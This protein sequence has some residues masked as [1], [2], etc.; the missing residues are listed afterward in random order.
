MVPVLYMQLGDVVWKVFADG[1]W[2][3]V[4]N[5]EVLLK[6]VQ[7]VKQEVQELGEDVQLSETQIA[8]TERVLSQTINNLSN[9][10]TNANGTV[11]ETNSGSS[12][13]AGFVI[14]LKAT[15]D[16]TIAEAGFDTRPGI[17]D[18]Q[19]TRP[20]LLALDILSEQA[21][22]T[23][24]ILDGGDGYENQFEVPNVTIVGTTTDVRD[25]RIV[26]ITISD[27]QGNIVEAQAITQDNAYSATGVVLTELMEG[28]LSVNAAVSD[29][30]GNSISANDETIKDTLA[31]ITVEADGF[32]DDY[33]NA[34]EVS[35]SAYLGSVANVESGQPINWVITDEQGNSITGS[36]TVD[37]VGVW[38]VNTL[39]V[40]TLEDGVLIIEAST[41][42]IA[43]NPANST[44][45]IIKDTQAFITVSIDDMDGV[46]NENEITNSTISGTVTD[47][48]DGQIVEIV[49]TGQNGSPLNL[50]ATVT[51]SAWSVSGVDLSSF[52][53]GPLNVVASTVDVAGN[54]ASAADTSTIDVV[55]PTIDIDTLQ[56]FNILS[57]RAGNLTTLQGTTGL[58]EEGLPVTVIVSDGVTTLEFQGNV[59]N[60]GNWMVNGIDIGLLDKGV[61]WTLDAKVSNAV[62]NTAIDDMPTIILPESLAFSDTVVGIFGSQDKES[63]IRIQNADFKFYEE[64][65]LI[66]QL[67]S[68]GLSITVTVTN[69]VI[70]GVRSDGETVFIATLAGDSVNIAF[71]EVIDQDAP[72][73]SI[74]TALLV[75]GTQTDAD[76]TTE[77]VIGHLPINIV[78]I[79]PVLFND[80]YFVTE[81]EVRSG[82]V[83]NNDIDLDGALTIYKII[84]DNVEYAIS[85]STPTVVTLSEGQLS[86]FA[87]GH[88]NFA[89][90]RNQDASTNPKIQ[91][92][93]FASDQENDFGQA[94]ATI[95]IRDGDA[96]EVLEGS[97]SFIE[98]DADLRPQT[99]NAQFS[100]APGSDNPDPNSLFFEASTINLLDNLALTSGANLLALSYSLNNDSTVITATSGSQT[101]FTITLSG[102]V[103]SGDSTYVTGNVK[104]ILERPLNHP[105]KNDLLKLPL[106]I[107][108]KDTDGTDLESGEFTLLIEDGSDPVLTSISDASVSESDVSTDSASGAGQFDVALGADDLDTN[109]SNNASVY[110]EIGEQPLVYSN[111]EEV[112]Y[113]LSP[114]GSILT[115]YIGDISNVVFIISFT[116]PD[117]S[118]GGLVDYTFEL[119]QQIDNTSDPMQLP[120]IVTA[121]DS[122]KDVTK[123]TLNVTVNDSGEASLGTTALDVTE[124]PKGTAPDEITTS[125]S[126]AIFITASE[127]NIVEVDLGITS[128]NAVVDSLG[129]PITTN[130][131]N[132]VWRDNGDKTFD[133]VD[134]NGV[135]VFRVGLPND[136]EVESG[137]TSSFQLSFRVFKEVDHG[138]DGSLNE[139][140]INL[141]V[142]ARDVD[143]TET[144]AVSTVK[145]YDG[146]DPSLVTHDLAIYE[147]LLAD[148]PEVDIV[149]SNALEFVRGS[150]AIVAIDIDLSTF[151]AAGYSSG[152]DNIMLTASNID[153]WYIASQAI[154]GEEV[155]RIRLNLDGSAEFVLTKP[156]DHPLGN[157]TNTLDIDF[158]VY[159][160]DADGDISVVTNLT[161]VVTDDVPSVTSETLE[162]TEG[163]TFSG[164]LLST[165][166]M[167]V[168]GA[169]ITSFKYE[170]TEYD[171]L[172]NDPEV[173]TLTNQNNANSSYGTLTLHSDGRYTIATDTNVDA[174]P[175]LVDDIEF[176][177]TDF[178]G[179]T[180]TSTASL[181]LDDSTG[182]IRVTN[183]EIREDETATLDIKVYVGDF[184]Q[185]ENVSAITLSDLQGGTLYLDSV[186]LVPDGSGVVTLTDAQISK[187]AGDYFVPDGVLTYVPKQNES[188]TTLTGNVV[189]LVIGA[190]I[191]R[192]G[193]A[194]E[195]VN[196][197]NLDISVLPVADAPDWAS[198]QFE[199]ALTEDIDRTFPLNIDAQLAD[200]D[201]SEK[202]SYQIS[203]IPNGI[204]IKLDGSK[205]VEG[206]SYTQSQLDQMTITVHK[207]L[208]G[209]FSFD[210]KAIATEK[211]NSFSSPDDKTEEIANVVVIKVSPDADQPELTVKDIRGLED[212]TIDLK[213]AIFGNL[214]D[215]DGS[216]TLKYDIVVQDG[217]SFTGSGYQLISA[218]TYRVDSEAI[219]NSQALLVPKQD[220][221]S[222]TESL[223]IQVTAVA[224][225]STIDGLAPVN[226]EAYSD[227]KTINIHLKGVVDPPIA[228]DGGNG[229]WDFDSNTNTIQSIGSFLEDGLVPLD[230]EFITSD[231]DVSETLNILITNIPDDISLVDSAG[232]PVALTIAEIDPITGNIYQ[233]SNSELAALYIKPLED[234]SGRMT[235]DATVVS[236]EQDGDSGSFD[237]TVQIDL[238]PVVDQSDGLSVVTTG[239][240]DAQIS[241][242]L[243]PRISGDNDKS[244]TLTGYIIDSVPSDLTLYFDGTVISVPSSGLDLETLLD[245]TT[246]TLDSLLNS[247]RLSVVPK[248][249]LS[250]TFSIPIRYEVTDTSGLGDTSE[251]TIIGELTIAVAAKVEI[252]T[253]LETSIDLFVSDDGSPVDVSSAVKF[254]DEDIDGSEY[255]DYIILEI[256][257]GYEL[258]VTSSGNEPQQTPDGNWL[259]SAQGLTSDSI[260]ELGKLILDGISI[261]S[262]T[263]TPILDI[264]VKA[265]VVDGDDARYIDGVFQIQVTGHSG[266]GQ[267]CDPIGPPEPIETGDDIEFDEGTEVLDLSGLL[268]PDIASDPDNEISFYVPTSSLPDGVELQGNG[269]IPVYDNDGELIGYSISQTGLSNLQ[270]TGLDED[271]AGCLSFSIETTETSSCDGS[272]LTTTQTI[273]IDIKP[274]VDEIILSTAFTDIDEDVT[275]DLDLTLVL[276]D[277]IE[278]GQTVIGEGDSATGKETVNSFTIAVSGGAQLSA[279][280]DPSWLV[281]NGDGSWTLTD[282]TKLPEVK[283]VPPENF[284]GDLSLTATVSITDKT[285]CLAET[286]TQI[287]TVTKIVTI[288]PIVD[289]ADLVTTDILGDEDSYISLATLSADLIDKDG[290]ENMSLSLS[291]VPE[292]AVVVIK[293][294]SSY[295][296]VPNNGP[297][298]GTFNGSPTYEWQLDVATLN[299]T[300]ILPPLDFSGDIPL[301]L[302]AI[303]QE[304]ATGDTRIT[305][306]NFTLGVKPIGD[307]IE[308]FGLPD[309]VSGDEDAVIDIPV[310]ITSL[311]TNS[312]ES[313]TIVVTV[314]GTDDPNAIDGI[315]SIRIDG[316]TAKFVHEGN[317]ATAIVI[318]S[319]SS[320]NNIELFA[321]NAF[322]EIDMTITADTLDQNT[323]LGNRVYDAGP[324]KQG[325]V[326]LSITPEPDEPILTLE[327]DAIYS[328]AEGNIPLGL[329]LSL[330][331]PADSETGKLT[332][333]GLPS[334]ITLSKGQASGSDWVVDLADVADLAITGYPVIPSDSPL[335]FTL[336]LEPSAELNGNSADGL[337]TELQITLYDTNAAID[338][339]ATSAFEDDRFL[340]TS[341]SDTFDGRGGDDFIDGGNG[342]DTL[343]GGAGADTFYF[344]AD[345]LGLIT[346]TDT[347]SDY[348]TGANT[349]SIDLSD[350]LAGVST[351]AEAD[352]QM[353]L[354]QEGSNVRIDLKPDGTTVKHHIVLEN[355]TLEQLYGGNSTSGVAEVDI[356]QKMIDDQNLILS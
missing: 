310:E 43:G 165:S 160:T 252:D 79:A 71:K 220:I 137:L 307:D 53:N 171:F 14:A 172:T 65:D 218:N 52:N 22:I 214:T 19:E 162:L 1:S 106:L 48:E 89:A 250:D 36:S 243:E 50:S 82:N 132:I 278:L 134:E 44:D 41:I 324:F 312:D 206:K 207:D 107:G 229:N 191:T 11:D 256:P 105:N 212:Q 91:F 175:A 248:E 200:T 158:P 301:E 68:N 46:I 131:L 326:H 186:A 74:Q 173:I 211:G 286:D 144:T 215:T 2:E 219:L 280:G 181:I 298:G 118:T 54:P 332:I 38:N 289:P 108:G 266:G 84:V 240:E 161:V 285:D 103:S 236:T 90:N 351:A 13:S 164:N 96:G 235:F 300:F 29:D 174:S 138:N 239:V 9:N 97:T 20:E 159:A 152:G 39:D 125:D 320:I 130:G 292:G 42:D 26:Q 17:F 314:K 353:D 115:G 92:D 329:E 354:V 34:I 234:F 317:V 223:S 147:A 254:I 194:D 203:N 184:D 232:N 169:T 245:A 69:R 327:Y 27:Q 28:P 233:V 299:D 296:L 352:Q 208:A 73:N 141:P 150:D 21:Q 93:Y 195:D 116:S 294:G 110:F 287:K 221:S 321:G 187:G 282:V 322:G 135:V 342:S 45:T 64:Q 101:V 259:I 24:D 201:T 98:A 58:V 166:A 283:L 227:S 222:V 122:D 139:L 192:T 127:D 251:K 8:D 302:R 56:G 81:G 35:T 309:S 62:G 143:G 198:S 86:V 66:D 95:F 213:E 291:G 140:S 185:N 224:I 288:N 260:Q 183:T 343:T 275:T 75:Q 88:Y 318:V 47:V 189:A 253:R 23:V 269:V 154:S 350:I 297:D 265:R 355:T 77:V 102:A 231:D 276:G 333:I 305:E 5:D 177:V 117:A 210:I 331:N 311:E 148:S 10:I 271:F 61:E 12:D 178:D 6:G 209:E 33:L 255:L 179:D 356:I 114:T 226:D 123:L 32:G 319:A 15:L 257:T 99:I 120:F 182:V 202:L 126:S 225:E 306:S 261:E 246:P 40:T 151:N 272:S 241:L 168:D 121:R 247:G 199:Y 340:G 109:I 279:D 142:V 113:T 188:N 87:N 3:R 273:N 51:N 25:G 284:S 55:K 308:F 76:G 262:K 190:T 104:I 349:D 100:V 303:T 85:G 153:D 60:S 341:K 128:G 337:S 119:K 170:S 216:E 347:I 335:E 205:I 313:L 193:V 295:Q 78:D 57:F 304:L 249:D 30:F 237:Y 72:L 204:T 263:D 230:F 156:L 346:H 330:V 112:L 49:I 197:E 133:G 290:S 336:T 274:V 167:G 7:F 268:D 180:V 67:T 281:D 83:L 149:L 146:G 258:F 293:S 339:S 80:F 18:S 270:I 345:E 70:T 145:I 136:Y 4:S 163:E 348:D 37:E 129:N 111:G 344:G 325:T 242:N 31:N 196:S 217:W 63:D 264:V 328:I 59:D 124:L 334:D 277:S 155:F 244:E 238:L 316:K 16:E 94:T 338:D 315:E 228:Q 323:V 267:P 176:T 157:G